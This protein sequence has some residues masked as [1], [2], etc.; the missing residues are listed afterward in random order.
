M[1]HL[2]NPTATGI[3]SMFGTIYCF[4]INIFHLY[5]SK[6]SKQRRTIFGRKLLIWSHSS[7]LFISMSPVFILLSYIHFETYLT[8]NNNSTKKCYCKIFFILSIISYI[9]GFFLLKINYLIRLQMAIDLKPKNS[10]YFN[11]YN[12]IFKLYLIYLLIA[13]TICM[14]TQ[15]YTFQCKCIKKDNSDDH[16]TY[17]LGC[18]VKFNKWS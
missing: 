3:I 7:M 11:K 6:N 2:N 12:I 15:Y 13:F 17:M 8:T 5:L 4:I 14:F 9:I 10:P 18:H 1:K 16:D